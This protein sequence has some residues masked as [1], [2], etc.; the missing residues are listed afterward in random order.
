[1]KSYRD[2]ALLQITK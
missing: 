2:G 1:M